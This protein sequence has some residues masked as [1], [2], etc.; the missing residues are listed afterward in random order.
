MTL[1]KA[2][3]LASMSS[4]GGCGGDSSDAE[5]A[6]CV[7]AATRFS[8]LVPIAPSVPELGD[9]SDSEESCRKRL[10]GPSPSYLSTAV[11]QT[12]SILGALRVASQSFDETNDEEM[13]PSSASQTTNNSDL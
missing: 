13:S 6:A 2:A 3:A 10:R 11:E 4:P 1:F 8:H 5:D 9:L 12:S 7:V